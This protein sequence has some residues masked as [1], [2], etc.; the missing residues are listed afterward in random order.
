MTKTL[1]GY[2]EPNAKNRRTLEERLGI[3]GKEVN[4]LI[5]LQE[6]NY[7]IAT[8]VNDRLTQGETLTGA[9]VN[10]AGDYSVMC[11][12]SSQWGEDALTAEQQ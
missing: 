6:R 10:V 2:S 9:A 11:R 8:M 5:T 4:K 3:S 1:V 7:K 12:K